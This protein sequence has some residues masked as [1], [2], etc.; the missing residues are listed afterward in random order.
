MLS[1]SLVA[2]A[3]TGLI[4]HPPSGENSNF[5]SLHIAWCILIGPFLR[6]HFTPTTSDCTTAQETEVIKTVLAHIGISFLHSRS[7]DFQVQKQ[8]KD[9]KFAGSP[10]PEAKLRVCLALEVTLQRYI[11]SNCTRSSTVFCHQRTAE[12]TLLISR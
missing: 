4:Y 11:K 1:F 6:D 5:Q 10:D 3:L 8:V 12:S 9:S 7:A 2:E